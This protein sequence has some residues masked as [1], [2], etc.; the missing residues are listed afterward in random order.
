MGLGGRVGWMG[1]GS[2]KD[3]LDTHSNLPINL[4][5]PGMPRDGP[6]GWSM[7]F[8]KQ[9]HSGEVE[10]ARRWPGQLASCD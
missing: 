4:G 10:T 9:T 3:T 8:Y 5:R 2:L 6:R 7:C 1:K